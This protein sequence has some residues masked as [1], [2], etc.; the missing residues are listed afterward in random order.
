LLRE[1]GY[2]RDYRYPHDEPGGFVDEWNLPAELGD[3]RFYEPS[4]NGAES[5]VAERLADWRA[6]R[7]PRGDP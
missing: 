7:R 4:R 3:A 1:L 2:A 5:A 6:R